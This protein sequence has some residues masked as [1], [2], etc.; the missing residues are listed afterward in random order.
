M[1]SRVN[2][3]KADPTIGFVYEVVD[4]A[5]VADQSGRHDSPGREAVVHGWHWRFGI[6]DR[7]GNVVT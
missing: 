1:V 2:S 5:G 4:G 7:A 6:V 3:Y